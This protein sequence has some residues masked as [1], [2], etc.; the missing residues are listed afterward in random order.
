MEAVHCLLVSDII[1]TCKSL[2]TV[3]GVVAWSVYARAASG[4]NSRYPAL[5]DISLAPDTCKAGVRTVTPVSISRAV[6]EAVVKTGH[7]DAAVYQLGAVDTRPA[8]RTHAEAVVDTIAA[9]IT[10]DRRAR[11]D[12]TAAVR[13]LVTLWTEAH[14]RTLCVPAASCQIGKS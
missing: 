13:T 14:V 1:V 8:A 5:V 4:A 11:I 9:V 2:L 7:A 6:A 10:G 3:T 12:V